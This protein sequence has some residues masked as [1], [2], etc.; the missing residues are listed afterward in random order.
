MSYN[1][2]LP[3][4]SP[5]VQATL[6]SMV[7]PEIHSYIQETDNAS[8]L[9]K[10]DNGE[11]A[12]LLL[13]TLDLSH[14]TSIMHVSTLEGGMEKALTRLKEA[15][16]VLAALLEKDEME[17]EEATNNTRVVETAL[18]AANAHEDWS[19][20]PHQTK[21][22]EPLNVSHP[23]V[24]RLNI[25]DAHKAAIEDY[26]DSIQSSQL[27][28][29][30]ASLDASSKGPA[31]PFLPRRTV[32]V[33]LSSNSHRT[34]CLNNINL[35][36]P[37][38]IS[39]WKLWANLSDADVRICEEKALHSTSAMVEGHAIINAFPLALYEHHKCTTTSIKVHTKQDVLTCPPRHPQHTSKMWNC[40]RP[41]LRCTCSQN[42]KVGCKGNMIWFNQS[43]WF[44]L[45][46]LDRFFDSRYPS[47]AAKYGAFLTWI[48]A[49]CSIAVRAQITFIAYRRLMET[50]AVELAANPID[51]L[52][53]KYGDAPGARQIE[54]L[55]KP[56]S[57]SLETMP[58]PN[59]T[60]YSKRRRLNM[61]VSP[62]EPYQ[63]PQNQLGY[64]RSRV[65][66]H[67]PTNS[68]GGRGRYN[69]SF[70]PPQRSNARFAPSPTHQQQSQSSANHRSPPFFERTPT[71]MSGSSVTI[72][73]WSP[74]K[75]QILNWDDA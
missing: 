11:H 62:E 8:L 57:F 41:Y 2:P 45:N 73:P 40:K 20:R 38:P 14:W 44:I 6:S 60:T 49:A 72:L 43:V 69:K 54:R 61:N 37:I 27:E 25:L 1:D 47:L 18:R 23:M 12:P 66:E 71:S 19:E 35:L 5:A 50:A 55:F 48:S 67:R 30:L 52:L 15:H 33:R 31:I 7:G 24:D 42:A 28:S 4:P 17:L 56:A 70:K 16:S 21:A 26:G 63:Q 53:A 29:E 51:K 59:P 9:D 74:M 75:G 36:A 34:W 39:V 13:S 32:E 22:T 58:S 10:D 68:G 64:P 46:N 3:A 65:Q